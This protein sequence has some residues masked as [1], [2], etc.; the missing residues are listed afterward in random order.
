MPTPPP[1][2]P[3]RMIQTPSELQ[4]TVELEAQ[5]L[6]ATSADLNNQRFYALKSIK[7]TGE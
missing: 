4:K 2:P 1:P 3:A 7:V 6:V 5:K